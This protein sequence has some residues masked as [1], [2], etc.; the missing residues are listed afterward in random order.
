MLEA[1]ADIDQRN[2]LGNT[3]LIEATIGN[4]RDVVRLLLESGADAGLR[5]RDRLT[6]RAI[7]MQHKSD[8]LIEEFDTHAKTT[9]V[10]LGSLN[11]RSCKLAGPN[12]FT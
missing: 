1:G 3:A 9:R 5:N 8:E 12:S 4:R 2:T 10:F 6:A 7:A 11:S